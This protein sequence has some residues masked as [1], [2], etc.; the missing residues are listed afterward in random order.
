[1][2]FK[3]EQVDDAQVVVSHISKTYGISHGTSRDVNRFRRVPRTLAHALN[4]VSL[5]ARSG[6]SIGILGRNGSGKST[7]LRL[8]A[9]TEVPTKGKVLVRSKP[10]MMGVRPALL[11]HLNAWDNTRIGLLAMGLSRS[12]ANSLVGEV[13]EWTGLGDEANR[14][15]RTYSSGQ[16]AR[17]S[18]AI[19]TVVR[20]KILLVD[21]ALATGD[22]GFVEKARSR[23]EEVLSEAGTLF[24]VSHSITDVENMCSRAVWLDRG[25]I[26]ADGETAAV[27]GSY[28]K[29][30]HLNSYG[31]KE[32]AAEQLSM[33]KQAYPSRE[34]TLIEA[35]GI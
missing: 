15:M 1:M 5:L 2:S 3:N 32:A 34:F 22:M 7:L 30:Q 9:G 25:V 4:D 18:F 24:L 8:I 35:E 33:S 10:S 13:V 11:P 17:L 31:E 19:S 27:S 23:M 6:E 21:E 26:V 14:P 12:E 20:P 16:A 29:W 28:K